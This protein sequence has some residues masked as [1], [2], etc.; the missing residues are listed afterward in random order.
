MKTLELWSIKDLYLYIIFIRGQTQPSMQ[1]L[2]EA[3]SL[4]V[5]QLVREAGHSPATSAEVKKMW[6]YTS[7]APYFVME[8]YLIS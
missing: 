5:K 7:T 1:R 6:I 3:I 4:G 8:Q 2:L